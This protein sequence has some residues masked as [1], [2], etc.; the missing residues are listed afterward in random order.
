M[1]F[2]ILAVMAVR[3][4]AGLAA[5]IEPPA[6]PEPPQLSFEPGSYDFGL[7]SVNNGSSQANFQLRNTGSEAVHVDSVEISPSGD[8]S[9]W[10]NT[11]CPGMTLLPNETCWV[12]VYFGPRNA[13][14]YAVQLR[15]NS[16]PYAFTA[17]LTGT[18]GRASLEPAFNPTDFG[19]AKVGSAGTVHEITVTNNGNMPGGAFIAVISGGAIGSFQLLDENCTGRQLAPAA[20]CTLQ[21]RFRPLSEGVKTAMLGLFGDSDGGTQIA[22]T[23]VGSAPDPAPPAASG[24]A[25]AGGPVAAVGPASG[26]KPKSHKGKRRHLK[27]H[28]KRAAVHSA[29]RASW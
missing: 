17:E 10:T 26:H 29:A 13:S 16:G 15:A 24:P 22:L 2:T 5:P 1:V 4:V 28:S 9:F 11:I 8:G 6:E 23:G 14:E 27:R 20:T 7:Q 19:V 12:Q 3:P 18:G 21:V 25:A